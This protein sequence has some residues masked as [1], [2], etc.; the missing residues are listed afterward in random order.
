MD[1]E[2]I[3]KLSTSSPPDLMSIKKDV[4]DDIKVLCLRNGQ[5]RV[6]IGGRAL[7]HRGAVGIGSVA[8][9]MLWGTG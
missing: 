4:R 1:F 8:L 7:G 2:S 5:G 9:A 3:L 6:F